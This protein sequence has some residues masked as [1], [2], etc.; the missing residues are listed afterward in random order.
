MATKLIDKVVNTEPS[1][2]AFISPSFKPR[3]EFY[4]RHASKD[5]N[6]PQPTMSR[7]LARE[8]MQV[9]SAP[10]KGSQNQLPRMNLLGTSMNNPCRV[11]R[12]RLRLVAYRALQA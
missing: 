6:Q 1:G 8:R 2:R 12:A 4:A 11:E 10:P 5:A 3:P 9:T 7:S